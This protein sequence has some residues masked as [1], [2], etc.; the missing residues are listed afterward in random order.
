MPAHQSIAQLLVRQRSRIE[1]GQLIGGLFEAL[2]PSHAA[3]LPQ[4]ATS[5]CAYSG[6][7]KIGN[8]P[9]LVEGPKAGG[10]PSRSPKGPSEARLVL[11]GRP[12]APHWIRRPA[13]PA[14]WLPSLPR[15]LV[16]R[17]RWSCRSTMG[18][19]QPPGKGADMSARIRL[20]WVAL[21]A[22]IAAAATI[23]TPAIVAGI[24]LSGV[25]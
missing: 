22:A 13:P 19:R 23:A 17:W 11:D 12:P 20:L 24:T 25:D 6:H 15:C 3:T 10:R 16:I 4:S 2:D 14:S 18:G 7:D 8:S 5:I 9:R 21:L 1:A